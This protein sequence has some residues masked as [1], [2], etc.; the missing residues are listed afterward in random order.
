MNSPAPGAVGPRLVA[1]GPPW[2]RHDKTPGEPDDEYLVPADP[3]IGH[4]ISAQTN[5]K[6]HGWYKVDSHLRNQMILLGILGLVFG[7]F[8]CV[9]IGSVIANEVRPPYYYDYGYGQGGDGQDHSYDAVRHQ[10]AEVLPYI[11]GAGG[12]LV[13]CIVSVVLPLLLRRRRSTYVGQEGLQQYVKYHLM[14]PKLTTLRFADCMQLSV[15]RTRHFYNGAYSGT[16]Y[17]YVWWD[18]QA[19]N[20]FTIEGRYNDVQTRQTSDQV[21][22]AF[23]AES[24]WTA[25]KIAEVD[26]Q[27]AQTG[28]ARFN[29]GADYIG[30]GKGFLE[31][32]WRGQVQRLPRPDIQSLTFQAGWLVIKRTGAK[33]GWFSSDGV[34]RFPV[35]GMADFQVFMIVLA[36]QTGFRFN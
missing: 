15:S 36:E 20:A 27:I 35:S 34:F 3:A 13:I 1:S 11:T 18:R 22:F 26:R 32:G 9:G 10:I 21:N 2:P 8:L 7:G 17:R 23:A 28:M 5:R 25:H 6:R 4:V 30:I 14:G 19:K 16:S 24:A 12:G 29:V 33:E 31:I